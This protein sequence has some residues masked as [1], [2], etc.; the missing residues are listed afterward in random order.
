M[1][2]MES[3]SKQPPQKVNDQ[4]KAFFGEGGLG[5]ELVDESSGCLTFE[6]GGGHVSAVLCSDNDATRVSLE[7]REWEYHVRRFFQGLR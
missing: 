7:T 1:L 6:G 2:K 5:L 4:L 3:T